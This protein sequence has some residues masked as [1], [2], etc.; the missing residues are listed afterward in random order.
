MVSAM[1]NWTGSC[2][3]GERGELLGFI[4]RL[5]EMNDK[6]LKLYPPPVDEFAH[7]DPDFMTLRRHNARQGNAF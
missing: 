3:P 1:L 2:L 7:F 5:A 4:G 6:L